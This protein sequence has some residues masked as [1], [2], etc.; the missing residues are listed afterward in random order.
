MEKLKIGIVHLDGEG[1][2]LTDSFFE[3]I[4]LEDICAKRS[5]DSI[6]ENAI[7]QALKDWEDGNTD[8]IMV[9]PEKDNHLMNPLNLRGL[10]MLVWNSLRL[11]IATDERNIEEQIEEVTYALQR[12]FDI[13]NPRIAV[14]FDRDNLNA[15]DVVLTKDKD[16]AISEFL[17]ITNGNG[18]TYTTGRELIATSPF[19]EE[20]LSQCI[21][22]AKD[23]MA[24]RSRYDKARENPLPKLF[25]DRKEDARRA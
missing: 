21:Y 4:L 16:E 18:V 22:L 14:A 6:G 24:A 3:E 15:Y 5:Y 20:S 11:A 10:D 9:I 12:E 13:D 19:S 7:E 25:H 17:D 2:A 8:A 23:I 1:K